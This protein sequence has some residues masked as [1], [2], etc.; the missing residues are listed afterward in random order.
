MRT[1]A[2]ITSRWESKRLPGKALIDINGKPLLQWIIDRCRMSKVNDVVVATTPNSKPIV[3]YC[4]EHKIR[5][6]V[7]DEEDIVTRLYGAATF[8]K[9]DVIIRV[10]GDCPLIDPQI[11]DSLLPLT[12]D[13]FYADLGVKGVGA[14]RLTFKKLEHDHKTLTGDDRHWYHN[15]CW[16]DYSVDDEKSLARVRSILV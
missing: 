5:Y 12:I 15:Y 3:D 2:I 8:A 7:G 13:Y 4:K 16:P 9:A 10:W 6:F 1:V 14:A 11:I